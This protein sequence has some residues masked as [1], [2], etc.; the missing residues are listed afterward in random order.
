ML[1]LL[2]LAPCCLF[3]RPYHRPQTLHPFHPTKLTAHLITS[4]LSH[5]HRYTTTPHT[6]VYKD[7]EEW[8]RRSIVYTAGSGK[9]SS[10]RTIVEYAKDIW[11]VQPLRRPSN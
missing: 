5:H 3:V 9:F 2:L 7:Q 10:D 6:Q 8:T 1:A 4:P 11:N